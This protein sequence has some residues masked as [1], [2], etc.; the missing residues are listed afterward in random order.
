MKEITIANLKSRPIIDQTGT[1]GCNATKVISDYLKPSCINQFFINDTLKTPNMSSSIP[2]L[3]G[4]KEDV[5]YDVDK[6][7]NQLHYLTNLHSKKVDTNL[8]EI[9]FQKIIGNLSV[10]FKWSKPKTIL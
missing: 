4:A 6:R 2:P 3:Q 9:D 8:F 7:S 1:F 5:S 10:T